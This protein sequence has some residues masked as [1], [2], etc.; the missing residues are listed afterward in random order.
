MKRISPKVQRA[1]SRLLLLL[2]ILMSGR[3]LAQTPD[4][5]ARSQLL[6]EYA[7]SDN[8][9]AL[10]KNPKVWPQ[11]QRLLG[12]DLPHLQENLSVSG[13]VDVVG[14]DLSVSG[15][16]PHQGTVEEAVV[17]VNSYNLEVN[18]A[19]FSKGTITAYSR[20]KNYNDLSRCIKSWIT[21][22]NSERRD[23]VSQPKNVRMARGM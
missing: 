4:S 16:A 15:N 14:G 7:G 23:L 9:Y 17:C 12:K 6:R 1:G 20:T 19:V 5:N 8:W 21:L 18:A 3:A 22:V 13:A 2:T 10:L 11:L